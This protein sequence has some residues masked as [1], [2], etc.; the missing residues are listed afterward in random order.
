MSFISILH[1]TYTFK[2]CTL[3]TYQGHTLLDLLGQLFVTHT[4]SFSCFM[5]SDFNV[6]FIQGQPPVFTSFAKRMIFVKLRSN[7]SCLCV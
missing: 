7:H 1:Q 2:L 5:P 3:R 4:D 6:N